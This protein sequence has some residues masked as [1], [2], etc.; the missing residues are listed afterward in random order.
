MSEIITVGVQVCSA[1][2]EVPRGTVGAR[3]EGGSG[4]R[5]TPWVRVGWMLGVWA[6]SERKTDLIMKLIFLFNAFSL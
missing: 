6:L 3:R 2:N 4:Y 5:C 1:G